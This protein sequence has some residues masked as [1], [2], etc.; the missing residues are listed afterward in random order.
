ML[1][2]A[3]GNISLGVTEIVF[4]NTRKEPEITETRRVILRKVLD[5]NG[6]YTA[7][8]GA[9]FTLYKGNDN[10]PYVVDG[11]PLENLDSKSNGIF[12]IG[13]LPYGKY[14]LEEATVP[15]GIEGTH[16]W[17]ELTVSETGVICSEQ[18]S[19]HPAL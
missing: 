19:E 12:W 1:P 9:K 11:K 4:T 2:N 17:Y 15:D 14:A 3:T 13:E 5:N 18:M 16:W 6:S 8:E 10:S 7:L